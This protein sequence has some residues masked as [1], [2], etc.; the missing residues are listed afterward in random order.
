MCAHGAG[1]ST[2]SS[3][4]S[5]CTPAI[6]VALYASVAC[7]CSTPLGRP[8]DPDVNS[9]AASCSRSVQQLRDRAPR[10]GA[11]RASTTYRGRDRVDDPRDFVR[12]GLVVDRRRDR[13]EA[14]ARAVQQRNLVPVRRLP[15]DGVA[16]STPRGAQTAGDAATDGRDVG[17]VR[18]RSAARRA[19]G[20]PTRHRRGGTRPRGSGGTSAASTMRGVRPAVLPA[21]AGRRRAAQHAR[22]DEVAL[23]LDRARADAQPADVAV[24]ASRP[25]TRG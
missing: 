18:P 3:A 1:M 17:A 25:G 11:R 6:T 2:Q 10:R 14:P 24:H 9:T 12:A 19:T 20:G 22:A 7:V 13:A 4:S 15:R 5:P 21:V 8:L 16:G 23:D